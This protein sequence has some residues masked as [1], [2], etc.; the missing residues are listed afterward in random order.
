[1]RR[2]VADQSDLE[3]ERAIDD[4]SIRRHPAVGNPQ[5][6]LRTHHSLDVDAVDEL[7]DGWHD[8]PGEL[9]LAEAERAATPFGARPAQKEADELP[10]GVEAEASRHHRIALEMAGKEPQVRLHLE[11]GAGKAAAMLA[12]VVGYLADAIEHQHRR[13]RQLRACGKHLAASARQEV[14]KL[15]ARTPILHCQ[16]SPE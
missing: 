16:K 11:L 14:L 13:Q 7:L 6:E 5:H 12:A 9:D 3:V 2:D 10:Q 1:M 4:R 8:H 15:E